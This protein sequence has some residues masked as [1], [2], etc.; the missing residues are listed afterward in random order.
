[1]SKSVMKS[2]CMCVCV[3]SSLFL[4]FFDRTEMGKKQIVVFKLVTLLQRKWIYESKEEEE[5]RKWS[6]RRPFPFSSSWHEL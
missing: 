1:M 5:E 4:L 2:A 3:C 6:A